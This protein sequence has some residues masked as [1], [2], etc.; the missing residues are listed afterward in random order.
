M[1]SNVGFVFISFGISGRRK[2]KMYEKN[3]LYLRN[4]EF[5]KS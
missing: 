5:V 4:V 3:C 1:L 2:K